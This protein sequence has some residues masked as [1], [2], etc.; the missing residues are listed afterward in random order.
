[1]VNGEKVEL[2]KYCQNGEL[3]VKPSSDVE[4]EKIIDAFKSNPAVTVSGADNN[5]VLLNTRQSI[6]FSSNN[7]KY[8]LNQL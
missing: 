8:A 3:Q 6:T 1:M 2:A 7:L 5:N 4:N